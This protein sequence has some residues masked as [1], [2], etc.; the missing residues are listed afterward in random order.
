MPSSACHSA[1][2]VLHSF[3]TRRSSDLP[4]VPLLSDINLD[5]GAGE[6]VALVGPNGVGKTTLLL[7]LAGLP[8]PAAGTVA[9]SRPGMVFQNAEHQRSEEH[10]S[11]LQSRGQLVCRL[12]LATPL[13]PF[14]TLSL[15]DALPISP[16]SRCYPISTSTSGQGRWWRWSALT[17]SARPR[18]CSPWPDC[19]PRP[20]ELWRGHG[21]AWC[22]RT[23]STRDRKST[24]LN[25]SHVAS[26][27]AVFC[28]PLRSLRSTLFPYTTLFRSPHCP[29]AIRYQPRH[30]GRGG[31][32]AGRP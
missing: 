27:Y 5:I 29:V 11:E 18:C 19:R 2:S 13:P 28:L 10:T 15:H 12:L 30:R 1:P 32:G 3:P 17:A 16:L 4:I 31:G 24:R 20:R 9:G 25:S 26:S 23:P 7:T 6:V 14:Y 8:A 22:S 21:R